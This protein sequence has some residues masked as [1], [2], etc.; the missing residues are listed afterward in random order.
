MQYTMFFQE[1]FGASVLPSSISGW[2]YFLHSIEVL[3]YEKNLLFFF[4]NCHTLLQLILIMWILV[5]YVP[6]WA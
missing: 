3:T 6:F 1:L 4:L 5:Q 2:L